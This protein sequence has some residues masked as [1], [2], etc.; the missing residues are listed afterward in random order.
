MGYKILSLGICLWITSFFCPSRYVQFLIL[1]SDLVSISL[2]LILF[3]TKI[4]HSTSNILKSI[5]KLSKDI[6][7]L[8]DEI[9]NQR[10][11]S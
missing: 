8:K 10:D 3:E 4:L 2:I 6:K 5:N 7:I 9:E 1:G 11:T